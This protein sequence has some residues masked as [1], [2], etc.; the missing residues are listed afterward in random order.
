[1]DVEA[2][3]A[4]RELLGGA[5][6]RTASTVL[7][8]SHDLADVERLADRLAI[9]DRGRIVALGAPQELDGGAARRSSGSGSPTPLSE[10]D[11]VDLREPAARTATGAAGASRDDGG[12]GPLP[13][14][15]A[16]RRRR[17]SSPRSPPGAASAAR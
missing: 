3:A 2:R 8:T 16:R 15:R 12:R 1:M 6:R 13:R 11:R 14:R 9:L 5:P 17:R 7:L 10:P 4:T